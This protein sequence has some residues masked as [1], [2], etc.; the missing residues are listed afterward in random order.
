M[1]VHYE[2]LSNLDASFLA[3]ETRETH[4]HV[5]AVALFGHG[6]STVSEGIDIDLIRRIIES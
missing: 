2:R 4:M 5:G 1:S 3:L 6:P